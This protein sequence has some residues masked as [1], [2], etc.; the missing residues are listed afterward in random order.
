MTVWTREDALD[1]TQRSLEAATYVLNFYEE[2]FNIK[3]PLPKLDM[4]ALPQTAFIAIENWG[5]VT[6]RYVYKFHQ[7]TKT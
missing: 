5:L 2:Y 1:E 4:I 6:Y 3:Y 7:I